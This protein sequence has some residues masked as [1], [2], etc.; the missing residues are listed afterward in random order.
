MQ[1]SFAVLLLSFSYAVTLAQPADFNRFTTVLTKQLETDMLD[2]LALG[3]KLDFSAK[4]CSRVGGAVETDLKSEVAAWQ[5]RND[6]YIKASVEVLNAFGDRYFEVG[7]EKARQTY[8][9]KM[10]QSSGKDANEQ[11]MRKLNGANLDNTVVPAERNCKELATFLRDQAF[12]IEGMRSS[13]RA[14]RPY[15]ER[16]SAPIV[17]DIVGSAITSTF[18]STPHFVCL[19]KT[20]SL[21][22]IRE[23]IRPYI[24]DI[25]TS[26]QES[27]AAVVTAV[28]TAFPCPFSPAR[29]ELRAATRA[30]VVGTWLVPDA[31]GKLRHGPNSPAWGIPAGVPP[32][33]CEG[34]AMHE[35]GEYRVMQIRGQF[36]C[37]ELSTMQGMRALPRV[38]S[39]EVLP[40]GRIKI[41]RT[42][43]PEATEEWEF[44]RVQK[45][46][47]F[48]GIK[49]VTG[50]LVAYMRRA[51]GNEINVA[52]AFRH[53]Q[54]LR[55]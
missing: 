40:S 13:I 50:D 23:Q 49:F 24:K 34:I 27:F 51:P 48:F 42:D 46:F 12:E 47:E 15:M 33:R 22:E 36:L 5:K 45:E 17:M 54:A 28:Y 38:Q 44:F 16:K 52:Y 43:V 37:P 9:Q 20:S 19:G 1:K 2:S 29:E 35:S 18:K 21:S 3:M 30:D 10:G 39:W 26:K 7:G 4:L 32:V 6:P 8:L 31:S 55:N 25:D 41:T 11:V 14:L 53:F